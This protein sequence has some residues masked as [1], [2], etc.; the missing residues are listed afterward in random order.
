MRLV[1]VAGVHGEMRPASGPI[2]QS[3]RVGQHSGEKPLEAG[4]PAEP[5]GTHPDESLEASS[6]L[7]STNA[8]AA[9]KLRKRSRRAA[10][11]TMSCLD[12]REIGARGSR[13]PSQESF[14][15]HRPFGGQRLP[16]RQAR[17]KP[18]SFRS[19]DVLERDPMIGE[20]ARWTSQER[21]G[22]TRTKTSPHKEE[23]VLPTY[24]QGERHRA[25][26]IE[27]KLIVGNPTAK[28]QQNVEA[29]VGKNAMRSGGGRL[30]PDPKGGYI[31]TE[32][33]SRSELSVAT[34]G[35][36]SIARSQ[37]SADPAELGLRV[38]RRPP[39]RRGARRDLGHRLALLQIVV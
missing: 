9:R 3:P 11:D 28:R 12:D 21:L 38:K 34:H 8:H 36:P 4:D 18:P 7:A 27:S 16:F 25:Y 31:G 14:L 32:T 17:E 19:P 5:L 35:P 39:W 26:G 13:E 22:G 23:Q 24:N 10:Q 29:T 30:S 20:L 6:K 15:E 33:R 2:I 37:K 1:V